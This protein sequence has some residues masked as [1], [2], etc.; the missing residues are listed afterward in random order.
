MSVSPLLKRFAF[1]L[2]V[3]G[4]GWV[5]VNPRHGFGLSQYGLTTYNRFPLPGVDFQVRSG[6]SFRWVSKTNEPNAQHLA[7]LLEPNLP[8]VVILSLGWSRSVREPSDWVLANGT[9]LIP[10]ST[11]RGPGYVQRLA[12]ARSASRDS[13]PL[14]L[15]GSGRTPRRSRFAPASWCGPCRGALSLGV[16]M[17]VREVKRSA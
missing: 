12:S 4:A 1:L 7:W 6:G 3:A 11:G 8:E 15:L 9:R 17:E 5:V 14:D 13:C 10:S 16:T 2:I